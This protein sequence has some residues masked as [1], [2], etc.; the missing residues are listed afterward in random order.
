M[1]IT[2]MFKFHVSIHQ[3]FLKTWLE[4]ITSYNLSQLYMEPNIHPWCFWILGVLQPDRTTSRGALVAA[5]SQA[6]ARAERLHLKLQGAMRRKQMELQAMEVG[7]TGWW[8][9]ECGTEISF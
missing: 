6:A 5:A 7:L 3:I 1:I 2:Y 9:D 8:W 4:P